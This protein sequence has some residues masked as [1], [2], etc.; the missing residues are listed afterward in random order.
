MPFTPE[1]RAAVDFLA[2]LKYGDKLMVTA[3]GRESEM[4][5]TREIH[6]SDGPSGS[7]E[8]SQVTVSYGPGRYAFELKAEAMAPR[9]PGLVPSGS[10]QSARRVTP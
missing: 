8:S 9:H 1:F 2:S 10:E 7:Y 4:T 6:R 5:V 3:N